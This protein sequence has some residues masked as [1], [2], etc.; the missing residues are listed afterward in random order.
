MMRMTNW[1]LCPKLPHSQRN[2][3]EDRKAAKK[4]YFP[5]SMGLSF[6]VPKGTDE[7]DVAVRWGDYSQAEFEGE[8][9]RST[10][11]WQRVPRS[12]S[13]RVSLKGDRETNE[14]A[15]PGSAGLRLH[16]V[17]R[18]V[19]ADELEELLP[20]GTRAVS[21]FLV[22]HRVPNDEIPDLAYAFQAQLEVR[23]DFPFVP[24]PDLRGALAA[25]WD[26]QGRRSPLCGH[27]CLCHRTRRLRRLGHRRRTRVV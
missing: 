23:S 16:V 20:K 14:F 6:L 27:T 22:N 1:M 3:A 7:L 11:I 15:V 10:Q 5:S 25:E 13:V 4:G 24:R 19:A 9:G 26:E 12:E 18:T 21:V 8:D 17:Q 2:L